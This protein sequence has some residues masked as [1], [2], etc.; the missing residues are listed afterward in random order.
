MIFPAAHVVLHLGM[1]NAIARLPSQTPI[2]IR[3]QVTDR[4]KLFHVKKVYHITRGTDPELIV[5][6][7]S[8]Q[9][10]YH[11]Q[12]NA[13]KYGCSTSDFFTLF[14]GL[15][16][17]IRETLHSGSMA[18]PTPLLLAGT[19]PPSFLYAQPTF[20]VLDKSTAICNKPIGALLPVPIVTENDQT[21][22]YVWL[23]TSTP[24]VAPDSRTIALRLRTAT[25]EFHYIRLPT[26][27]PTPWY[28]WPDTVTFNVSSDALDA[29]AG[30]PVNTLL[31]PHLLMTSVRS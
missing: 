26:K 29:W 15:T 9:G 27:Y 14:P 24:T 18:P 25:G 23:P 2:A 7:D 22:F 28:G 3:V 11:L 31:C 21:A 30:K 8:Q 17:N 10:V 16:R 6:F 1:C 19:A 4:A 5:E 20:V 12:V 13:L